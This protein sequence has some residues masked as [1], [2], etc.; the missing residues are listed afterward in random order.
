MPRK[1]V[2]NPEIEKLEADFQE[3]W[4]NFNE[5]KSKKYWDELFLRVQN[6]CKAVL[7]KKLKGIF[8]EDFD[9]V[10]LD[11][12]CTVMKQLKNRSDKKEVDIASLINYVFK[13][14]YFTL[15]NPKR[16]FQ[17]NIIKETDLNLYNSLGDLTNGEYEYEED[18][19]TEEW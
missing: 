15:Y 11:A 2:I 7:S 4:K 1:K 5:T 17:D 6:A 14:A 13:P 19:R 18:I 3:C 12:T 16:A 10:V 8:R 9:E